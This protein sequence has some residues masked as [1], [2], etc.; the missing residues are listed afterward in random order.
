MASVKMSS[1]VDEEVWEEFKYPNTSCVD[2][3]ME[4]TVYYTP[5]QCVAV[6]GPC[7]GKEVSRIYWQKEPL[8]TWRR[9]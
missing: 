9:F 3:L 7:E 2:D 6:G 4:P 5:E 1:V 8:E